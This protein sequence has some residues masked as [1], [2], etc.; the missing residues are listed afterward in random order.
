MPPQPCGKGR[1]NRK[2]KRDTAPVAGHAHTAAEAWHFLVA[3]VTRGISV[4]GAGRLPHVH[5]G[6]LALRPGP[7]KCT[8]TVDWTSETPNQRERPYQ[9]WGA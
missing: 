7:K 4:L 1:I 2:P 6:F 5:G 9:L 8:D 3:P